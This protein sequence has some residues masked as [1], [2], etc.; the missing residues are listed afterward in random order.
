VEGAL[1]QSTPGRAFTLG[2]IAALPLMTATASAATIGTAAAKSGSVMASGIGLL[3]VL[4]VLLGPV[5]GCL[6]AWIGV[7]ASLKSAASERER[8]LVIRQTRATIILVFG[9]LVA[10]GLAT[11]LANRIWNTQTGMAIT[12]AVG[13]P[14][15]Y[16]VVLLTMVLRFKKALDR[17]RAEEEPKWSAETAARQAEAWK[18]YEYKSSRTFLGLPLLHI[19]TG[20]RRGEKLRPAVGWIAVGD[21]SIGVLVS[22][23][24]IAV[25]GISFG[26]LSLGLAAMGG[27][28][29]GALSFG[30]AAFGL[31]AATGGLAVGYLAHGGCALAWHAAQGGMAVARDFALGGSAYAAHAND[32]VAR[33]TI[34]AMPFF[35]GADA[36]S[37]QP[38]LINLVWLP[39][40]LIYWQARR[41]RMKALAS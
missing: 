38:L 10:M 2:V 23:G 40:L 7:K 15:L 35:R 22:V 28:A 17:V 16:V 30:G 29:F 25:G 4:G 26:G 19:R 3:G 39:L 37:R 18:T 11:P 31:W 13:L 27:A 34:G 21:L 5:I 12:L 9:F 24:G 32:A 41:V 33:E 36:F 20:R 8:D 6:G 1:R 14:V